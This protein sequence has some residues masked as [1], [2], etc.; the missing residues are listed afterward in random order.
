MLRS[1]VWAG[2]LSEAAED[3]AVR[4][5]QEYVIVP[6]RAVPDASGVQIGEG[7]AKAD[8]HVEGVM[9]AHR[10]Q[11]VEG[12]GFDVAQAQF[13]A[14]VELVEADA[15]DHAVHAGRREDLGFVMQTQPLGA[16]GV[17]DQDRFAGAVIANSW[18]SQ[19]IDKL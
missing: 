14:L 7:G 4:L 9:G 3:R 17:L 13:A 12:G 18:T 8:E 10:R 6:E 11:L 5:S 16:D 19:H 1:V 15:L 2:C